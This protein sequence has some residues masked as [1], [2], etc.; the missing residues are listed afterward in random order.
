MLN[1]SGEV[2]VF[3]SWLN[4]TAI[5]GKRPDRCRSWPEEGGE[6]CR[7]SGLR[8]ITSKPTAERTLQVSFW[9]SGSLLFARQALYAAENEVLGPC[10]EA[11]GWMRPHPQHAQVSFSE[12][13]RSRIQDRW[14]KEVKL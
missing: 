3:L 12:T 11:G 4:K 14:G 5:F 2:H 10:Q 9:A 13:T 1:S 7:T 6:G 8:V